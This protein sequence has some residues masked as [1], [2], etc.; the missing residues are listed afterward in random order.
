MAVISSPIQQI[1]LVTARHL[2]IQPRHTS[3]EMF[4]SEFKDPIRWRDPSTVLHRRSF[5]DNRTSI[6]GS[7]R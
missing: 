3:L 1:L 7:S 5:A 4:S 6:A 2:S